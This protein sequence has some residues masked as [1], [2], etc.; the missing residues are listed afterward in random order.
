MIVLK[1][2]QIRP[3]KDVDFFTGEKYPEYLK[4]FAEKYVKPGRFLYSEKEFFNDEL[5]VIITSVWDSRET[6]LEFKNDPVVIETLIK[7][8]DKYLA[9]TGITDELVSVEEIN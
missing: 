7:E 1:K 4:H 9:E 2:R 6:L 8:K 5:E 3:S